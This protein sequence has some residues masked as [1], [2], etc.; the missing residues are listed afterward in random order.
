MPRRRCNP[1]SKKS[2]L[3]TSAIKVRAGLLIYALC[4][5]FLS[6]WL[7]K[8][9]LTP[10]QSAAETYTYIAGYLAWGL[11]TLAAAT[12]I[13]FV[14]LRRALR[15][16]AIDAPCA[17]GLA[18]SLGLIPA[19][20][21]L[22]GTNGLI[23]WKSAGA[24]LSTTTP[25]L[26]WAGLI[27]AA[28]L[29]FGLA[30]LRW[31]RIRPKR[32]DAAAIFAIGLGLG[33]ISI[34]TLIMGSIGFAHRASAIAMLLAMIVTGARDL[35]WFLGRAMHGLQR[36]R[37]APLAHV[38]IWA[39]ILFFLMLN[40]SRAWTPPFDYDSLE[41]HVA[42]PAAYHQAGRII[43]MDW[44]VYA[45]FPQNSEM[46]TYL[47]ME[48]SRSPATGVIV[49][50]LLNVAMGFLT[51]LAL[52][53]MLRGVAGKETGLLAAAFFYTWPGVTEYG[54]MPFVELPLIFYGTLAAWAVLW[55][56]RR[57][58]TAPGTQ[59]WL[60]LAGMSA[61]LAMGV[62]YTAVLLV[63]GPLCLWVAVGAFILRTPLKKAALNGAVFG[64]CALLLFS[65]WM[66]RGIIN[67]GNP[68]YPLLYKQLGGSDWSPEQDAKWNNAHKRPD[69][70]EGKS[71][72]E[73]LAGELREVTLVQ[74]GRPG[75]ETH[76]KS[77]VLLIL[78]IPFILLRRRMRWAAICMA[79]HWLL[80]YLLY[81]IFTQHNE[82][83]LAVGIPILAVLSA[84]G[85]GAICRLPKGRLLHILVIGLLL[86]APSR[87]LN[88]FQSAFTM[89]LAVGAQT[90][91][92]FF[93]DQ[94]FGH[95]AD[96]Q[97]LNDPKL[98]PP[99]AK[100][101]FLGDAKSFYCRRAAI[102]P[103]VFN[104]HPL[105]ELAGD[106][107]TGKDLADRLKKAGFTHLYVHTGE[108]KRLQRTYA[109]EY[110]SS[111]RPGMLEGFNWPLFREFEQQH[112]RVLRMTRLGKGGH[113]I[114]IYEIR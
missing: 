84:I 40:L 102:A 6:A 11:A 67:T 25:P 111:S 28:A 80:L 54:G 64:V 44:N 12:G 95:Y 107:S 71:I 47:G 92:E 110:D 69:I 32:A 108:L 15:T 1:Q 74:S 18:I 35:K 62:K 19:A 41:Y 55:S 78:F 85:A 16:S 49:G 21:L 14:Y 57:K 36:L 103:T 48:L 22:F 96:M 39:I 51:A 77:T 114:A 97:A 99:D 23:E 3:P 75:L 105:E 34:A 88:Y 112:T 79:G 63:F 70:P 37:R 90:V 65:P 2:P 101:L 82:R 81:F 9:F 56:I 68:V 24:M 46:L 30:C 20:A 59:G 10:G 89:P 8:R 13:G 27:L 98:V 106:A 76:R 113:Y 100:V 29:S 72:A 7:L 58:R 53:T 66:I 50:N 31:L 5:A 60:A 91:D 52:L 61:G 4:A 45:N 73:A 26:F 43:Y 33:F 38:A 109:Y 87:M 93:A 94:T 104:H 42:A 83:F 86:F 17:I